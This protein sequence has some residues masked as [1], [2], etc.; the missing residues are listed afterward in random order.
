[1]GGKHNLLSVEGRAELGGLDAALAEH[2]VVL[3]ELKHA[4]SVALDDVL[5]LVH[6]IDHF[7]GTVKVG[8]ASV[9]G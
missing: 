8:E 6:K 4:N 5:D 2:V 9:I 3:E 1:V 7:L